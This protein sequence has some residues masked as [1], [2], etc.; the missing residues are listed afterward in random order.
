MQLE[1]DG[2]KYTS[3]GEF[4]VPHVGEY[5]VTKQGDVSHERYNSTRD[6]YHTNGERIILEVASKQ[7]VGYDVTLTPEE[8]QKFM[9]FAKYGSVRPVAERAVQVWK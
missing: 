4:R 5:Y 2:V 7:I 3:T 1:L 9:T 8:H 6:T